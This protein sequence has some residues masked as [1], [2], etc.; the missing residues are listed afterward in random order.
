VAATGCVVSAAYLPRAVPHRVAPRRV[1]W[2]EALP[3]PADNE[4]HIRLVRYSLN[5]MPPAGV[6]FGDVVTTSRVNGGPRQGGGEAGELR[7]L[8]PCDPRTI[9][10]AGS[11][12]RLSIG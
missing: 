2:R 4:K 7:C 12:L 11:K 6:V 10:C 8:S 1:G 5:G 3:S 9:I